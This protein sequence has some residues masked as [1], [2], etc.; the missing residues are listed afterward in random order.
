MQRQ[1]ARQQQQ[2][3]AT[4]AHQSRCGAAASSGWLLGGVRLP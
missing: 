3:N 2:R 1:Q 4:N